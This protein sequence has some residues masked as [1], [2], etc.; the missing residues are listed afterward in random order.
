[1]NLNLKRM[2]FGAIVTLPLTIATLPTQQASASEVM[3]NPHFQSLSAKPTFIARGRR[4][5]VRGHWER[6]H[7]GRRWVPPH[8][9]Y[10]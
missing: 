6:T 1:M 5:W 4:V 7:H 9:E 10:R 3:I 2:I 8:Y